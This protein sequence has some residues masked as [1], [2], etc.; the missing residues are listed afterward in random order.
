MICGKH[1]APSTPAGWLDEQSQGRM[2]P[3]GPSCLDAG[4]PP[5]LRCWLG[6]PTEALLAGQTL[7][8]VEHKGWVN[9]SPLGPLSPPLQRQRQAQGG[10]LISINSS[11][12]HS[13]NA[14]L[15]RMI[16]RNVL[17]DNKDELRGR[18]EGSASPKMSE[19]GKKKK[20]RRL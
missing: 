15:R 6:P 17:S 14:Q 16:R 4:H 13:N 12:Q 1:T 18:M 7:R 3:A 11:Q 10:S 5:P 8:L 20:K 2:R 19:K 9:S